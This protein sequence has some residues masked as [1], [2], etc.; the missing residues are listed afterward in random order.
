MLTRVSSLEI[1]VHAVSSMLTSLLSLAPLVGCTY[2]VRMLSAL[3]LAPGGYCGCSTQIFSRQRQLELL[4]LRTCGAI[5]SYS[6]RAQILSAFGVHGSEADFIRF[7]SPHRLRDCFLDKILEI[8][9]PVQFRLTRSSSPLSFEDIKLHAYS[10]LKYSDILSPRPRNSLRDRFVREDRTVHNAFIIL[11]DQIL[12]TQ[13]R[14]RPAM[15]SFT[16]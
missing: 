1:R 12:F 11:D 2:F 5:H 6:A 15:R 9:I 13:S 8:C 7:E 4:L 3:I 14:E 10:A 16:A